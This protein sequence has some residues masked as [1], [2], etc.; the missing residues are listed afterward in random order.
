MTNR[1]LAGVPLRVAGSSI[2]S[3]TFDDE[4]VVIDMASGLYFSLRGSAVDAWAMV[5]AGAAPEDIAAAIA[6]RYEG[7]AAAIVPAVMDFLDVLQGH[8]L[9]VADAALERA[10][11]AAA[12]PRGPFAAP[13][14]ERFT[15]MQ[16]L[17]L[18]DP[19][20]EVSEAGWPHAGAPAPPQGR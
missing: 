6:G 13:Q 15:D 1:V 5:E 20:H 16:D 10:A 9:V 4:V 8:G 17:L 14:L 12:S 19:V 3:K 2:H 7:D 18:L 11:P